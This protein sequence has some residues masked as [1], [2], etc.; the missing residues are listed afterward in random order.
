MRSC[1]PSLAV[2]FLAF[3]LAGCGSDRSAREGAAKLALERGAAAQGKIAAFANLTQVW[4][5][6][7]ALLV[8]DDPSRVS[9]LKTVVDWMHDKVGACVS[10]QAA[11]VWGQGQT[12]F[13]LMCQYGRAEVAFVI[14]GS[15]RYQGLDFGVA[16]VKPDASLRRAA[17]SFV[18]GMDGTNCR[19][20]ADLLVGPRGL[21]SLVACQHEDDRIL[22]LRLDRAG[23]I[24]R[25]HLG[26]AQ[27]N[28]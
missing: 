8:V 10:Y 17:E 1:A 13:D 25:A 12:R 6:H 24:E 21:R 27:S 19:L 2:A 15:R 23:M 14:D 16:G 18:A 5:H 4:S 26:P 28:G 9:D 3:V 7:D 11:S 22:T 20:G